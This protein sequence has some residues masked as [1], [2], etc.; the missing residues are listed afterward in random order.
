M[1]GFSVRKS[2]CAAATVAMLSGMA[3][4]Q[5]L[6][7]LL[8][9]DL[10]VVNQVTINATSGL[11]STTITGSDGIGAY[12]EDFYNGVGNILDD[13]LVSGDL[14]NV[15]N[16]SDGTP[17]LFRGGDAAERGLN[18]WSWSDDSDVTFTVGTQAF[19]GSAT[20][21]LG[22]D[23]YADM[24][25][26]NTGGFLY[27]PAD[28]FDDVPGAVALGTWAVV[29]APGVLSLLGLGGLGVMRRRR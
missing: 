3:Q 24:L 8:T 4:A 14:T 23:A 27:F 12:M 19:T 16:A 6:D 1:A 17:N 25:A 26:G 2:F 15:G 21:T 7:T 10:S 13:T 22:A 29:P 5:Q 28:T 11:S 20:W 9:V 18:L